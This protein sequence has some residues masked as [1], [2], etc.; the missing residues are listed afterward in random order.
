[1]M[2]D[3]L[4]ALQLAFAA[5]VVFGAFI[6]RGMTGFGAGMVAIPLLVFV[7]PIRTAVPVVSVLV[8]VLFLFL[9][10]RDW[11]H[12]VREELKRLVPA[13]LLGVV[14][15]ALLFATLASALLLQLL[16]LFIMGY[17]VYSV[18]VHYF[19][20]PEVS[21]SERW[22]YPAGFIGGLVDTIFGGGGGTPVVIYMHLRRVGRAE[23]R[24]T[25]AALWFVE[26]V[27][28][29]LGYAVAGLYTGDAL[30][31]CVILLPLVWA[32]TRVGERIGNRISQAAFTRLVAALLF[33]TGTTLLLK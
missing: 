4:G 3:G 11:E 23:F 12:V 28:R 1:M 18:A 10:F 9:M 22:A 15:G 24:A 19:G 32:G 33:F 26:M 14:A 31:L 8:F 2:I 29:I 6:V 30:L 17:A 7:M 16:A 21:C 27:A 20:L 13:A 5:L 25:V